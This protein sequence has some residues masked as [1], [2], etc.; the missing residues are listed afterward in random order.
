MPFVPFGADQVHFAQS[1][2]KMVMW[3]LNSAWGRYEVVEALYA[4]VY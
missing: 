2:H 3:K 4:F 1:L